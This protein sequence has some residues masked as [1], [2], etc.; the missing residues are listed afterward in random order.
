MKEAKP[1]PPCTKKEFEAFESID[2]QFC[3]FLD[4]HPEI[5]VAEFYHR[6]N[7]LIEELKSLWPKIERISNTVGISLALDQSL[8]VPI[9]T[10]LVANGIDLP[11]RDVD[12]MDADFVVSVLKRCT[13]TQ[14]LEI[15]DAGS[16]CIPSYDDE[17]FQILVKRVAH[18]HK[19]LLA[20]LL[21]N[22]AGIGRGFL[23]I[24]KLVPDLWEH[25]APKSKEDFEEIAW[26]LSAWAM[27]QIKNMLGTILIRLKPHFEQKTET[28]EN[29]KAAKRTHKKNRPTRDQMKAR[30]YEVKEKVDKF[31][32]NYGRKPH[33]DEIVSMTNYTVVQIRSTQT[34]KSGKI[35]VGRK[36][37]KT[38]DSFGISVTQSESF[39][40]RTELASKTR[41]LSRA[42]EAERDKL[43]DKS[44]ADTVNDEKQHTRYLINKK[45]TDS[46]DY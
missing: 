37:A 24:S 26:R 25:L 5:T 31:T 42:E 28:E 12:H 34:Y 35:E 40:E 3:F 14:E 44:N 11:A 22:A 9:A 46:E 18:R 29:N 4:P 2:Q 6:R 33:A 10:V 30:E 13:R 27:K 43:I 7:A 38:P 32:S 21:D 8:D 16:G 39:G 23:S 20:K 41:R 45:K 19:R 15:Y 36:V 1:I 17:A